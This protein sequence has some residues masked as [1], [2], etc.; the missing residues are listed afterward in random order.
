MDDNYVLSLQQEIQQ[1]DAD[2]NALRSELQNNEEVAADVVKSALLSEVPSYIS[3]IDALAQ[4]ADSESVKLQ[5]NK[6]LI[7]WAITDKLIT[8]TDPTDD[9]FKK[10]LKQ[11]TNKNKQEAK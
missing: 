6:L 4:A 3:N 11:L 7:E 8:G 2:L 9:E 1:K 10:L 5:A